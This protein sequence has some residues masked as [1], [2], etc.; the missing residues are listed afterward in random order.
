MLP[1]SAPDALRTA[2]TVAVAVV[3]TLAVLALLAWLAPALLAS[4]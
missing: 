1:D 4:G 2:C 3:I